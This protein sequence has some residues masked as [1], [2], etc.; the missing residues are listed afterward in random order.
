M[1]VAVDRDNDRFQTFFVTGFPACALFQDDQ[2]IT[3]DFLS[4]RRQMRTV[5]APL[6]AK[7]LRSPAPSRYIEFPDDTAGFIGAQIESPE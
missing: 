3:L 7:C 6:R 1:G 2:P 4:T 5:R